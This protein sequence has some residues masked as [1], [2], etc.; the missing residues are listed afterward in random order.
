MKSSVVGDGD[1]G[2]ASAPPK[3]L[4]CWKSYQ[5][6]YKKKIRVQI[7]PDVD[8]FQEMMPKVCVKTHEDLILEVT[9]KIGLH[10]FCGRKYV[11]KSFAKNFSGKFGEIREKSFAPQKFAC[12]YT[13]DEKALPLP[14][15]LFWK[16]RGD[17]ALAMPPF[18]GVPVHIILHAVSR[19]E[20]RTNYIT[21]RKIGV[22][23]CL[24]YVFHPPRPQH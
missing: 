22:K 1:A 20:A 8:S 5:K 12:S 7:A 10:D 3:V 21:F 16:G 9:P 14:L 6:L 23:T 19:I 2:V 15:P 4:I 17:D 13:Y 18:S 11:G 24:L